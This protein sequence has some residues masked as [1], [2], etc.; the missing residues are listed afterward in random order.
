[1][2]KILI[3]VESQRHRY[4]GTSCELAGNLSPRE[5]T[6]K[7]QFLSPHCLAIYVAAGSYAD[8]Y[9]ATAAMLRWG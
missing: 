8:C 3:S 6:L 2:L 9:G 5:A 4:W 1:M 7:N